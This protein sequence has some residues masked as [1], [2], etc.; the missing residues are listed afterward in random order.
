MSQ[1]FWIFDLVQK[2]IFDQV[3]VGLHSEE[4]SILSDPENISGAKIYKELS[5]SPAVALGE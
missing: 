2:S 4:E 3:N 5:E 1:L